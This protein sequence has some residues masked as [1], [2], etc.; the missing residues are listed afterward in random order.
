[1]KRNITFKKKKKSLNEFITS[2]ST[3]D[4]RRGAEYAY[5]RAPTIVSTA[6]KPIETAVI[7]IWIEKTDIVIKIDE[8]IKIVVNQTRLKCFQW[9]HE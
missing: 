9:Q 1:M 6:L 7:Q 4:V 5:P 3:R 8:K 2:I